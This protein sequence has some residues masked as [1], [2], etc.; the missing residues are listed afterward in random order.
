MS[1][2]SPSAGG[3][4]FIIATPIG[5]MEDIT[6]RAL[7]VLRQVAV[8]AAEDTRSARHLLGHHG[9]TALAEEEGGEASRRL[10]SFFEGNEA[11]R[12]PG[13]LADLAAGRDVALISEAGLPG[14][15]DPGQRLVAAAAAAGHRVEVLPGACAAVTAL[16]GSGLQSERFVFLGFPPRQEGARQALF[17][18]LRH[19]PGTLLF[20]EAPDRTGRTLAD[21]ELLLGPDRRACVARELTKLFEEYLRGTLAELAARFATT[22]PRG[23]ITLVVAGCS[24]AE[25]AAQSVPDV[26]A[27]VRARRA[28]GQSPK[29]IA[30]ALA[31]QTGKPR[32]YLYQLALAVRGQGAIDAED[33]GAGDAAE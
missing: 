18:G 30:A 17:A 32:R 29:E 31:L 24:A 16:I 25:A 11:Q 23:E 3:T 5:N 15:S 21:L 26:E 22:P 6:L 1:S 12:V 27:E 7:R 33:E 20:Y 14:V 28:Q 9:L 8:I 13:L 2:R 4:L 19:E 10:L